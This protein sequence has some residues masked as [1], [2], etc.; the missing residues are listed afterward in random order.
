M[1]IIAIIWCTGDWFL[2][3]RE[4]VDINMGW[5]K[6]KALA[7][8]TFTHSDGQL[9]NYYGVTSFGK[10]STINR[11]TTFYIVLK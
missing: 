4:L 5:E 6:D 7:L 1:E 2:L 9:V 8:L 10:K 11:G 3:E